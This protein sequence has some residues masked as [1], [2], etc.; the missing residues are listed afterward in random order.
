MMHFHTFIY[1]VLFFIGIGNSMPTPL[2]GSN[3]SIWLTELGYQKQ[4]IGLLALLGIPFSFKVLW[5]PILDHYTIPFFRSSPRKGWLFFSLMGLSASIFG[6]SLTDPSENAWLLIGCILSITFFK[7]CL[8]ITGLL[9]EIEGLEESCYGMGSAF[10]LTGYRIGLLLAGTGVLYLSF[11]WSWSL[12]FQ[13]MGLVLFIGAILVLFESEPYQSHKIIQEKK[14]RTAEYPSRFKAFWQEMVIVPCRSFVSKSNW[15]FLLF[16]IFFFKIGD[17]MSKSMEGPFYLSL[18][19]NKAEIAAAAKL[20]GMIATITGAFLAGLLVKRKDAV[21]S[22]GLFGFIH[23]LSLLCYYFLAING[24]SMSLLFV[25]IALE[26]FTSGMAM[27]VFIS[28]LWSIC[29]KRFAAVQYALL[30]SFFT[31][32]ADLF[33]SLGGILAS[34]TNWSTFFAIISSIGISSSLGVW[35]VTKNS[36]NT[37]DNQQLERSEQQWSQ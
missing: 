18:G 29:D 2:L 20:W 5:T 10:V 35:L 14:E 32:K 24:K 37:K 19:Y 12:A 26:H 28:Y 13:V 3:L 7:S 15:K 31:I 4:T 11:L 9:Y 1:L 25:T 23:G 36:L 21:H 27:T 8:Y 17:H 6:M 33:A 22:L 30:W 16:L 34:S